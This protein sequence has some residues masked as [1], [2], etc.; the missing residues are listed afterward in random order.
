MARRSAG[1]RDLATK[2]KKGRAQR[3]RSAR[4]KRSSPRSTPKFLDRFCGGG[5]PIPPCLEG[6]TALDLGCGAGRDASPAFPPRR[7]ARLRLRGRND[8]RVIVVGWRHLHC[9]GRK[10]SAFPRSNVEFPQGPV[11]GPR[12]A[13]HRQCVD[14]PRDLQLR[15][16]LV[17]REGARVRRDLPRPQAGRRALFLRR[18]RRPPDAA[19]SSTMPSSGRT[20]RRRDVRR[21]FSPH[22]QPVSAAPIIA[23]YYAKRP[24]Q[25]GNP[26]VKA[27]V[28]ATPSQSITVRAFK[29]DE[30]R[31]RRARTM[32]R[33]P[34]TSAAISEI[35]PRV[36]LGRA[37]CCQRSKPVRV[38]GNTAAMLSETRYAR[39][40]RLIGDRLR[41]FGRFDCGDS[42]RR[43]RRSRQADAAEA[44]APPRRPGD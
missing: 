13:R 34:P 3:T 39:H 12:G 21:G 7:P 33:S 8:P 11:R 17:A 25:I 38:S 14:R 19:C 43:R 27:R 26:E 40:F 5:S 37:P 20:P 41:H 30:P 10:V 24:A 32:D 28:G 35:P 36:P 18:V 16:D 23:W 22:A 42:R 2:A 4:I 29:L 6:C 44:W 9:A 1:A 31:G 15:A